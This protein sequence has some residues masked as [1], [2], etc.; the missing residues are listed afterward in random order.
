MIKVHASKLLK[1]YNAIITSVKHQKLLKDSHEVNLL[2]FDLSIWKN[3]SSS[4]KEEIST[5]DKSLIV[6]SLIQKI[7]FN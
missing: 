7:N 4:M 5:E 2:D 3:S 1:D 6:D